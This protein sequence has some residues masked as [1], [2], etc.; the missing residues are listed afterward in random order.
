MQSFDNVSER[1]LSQ[2]T[3]PSKD[4]LQRSHLIGPSMARTAVTYSADVM[5]AML[6]AEPWTAREY[7]RLEL[8]PQECA[9]HAQ[10]GHPANV[11]C[12]VYKQPSVHV[13]YSKSNH[14]H[15]YQHLVKLQHGLNCTTLLAL[16]LQHQLTVAPSAKLLHLTC[17][18]NA[19]NSA[20]CLTDV[21][22]A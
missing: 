16:C 5:L 3:E 7:D 15:H 22:Q 19:Q 2:I 4:V 14:M 18:K 11:M 17:D 21:C 10:L 9:L 8:G 6:D 1:K 20:R 13:T 12:Q